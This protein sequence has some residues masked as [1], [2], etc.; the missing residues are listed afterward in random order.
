MHSTYRRVTF[1]L[2]I[3]YLV[4]FMV[5]NL[6]IWLYNIQMGA[7]L[8]YEF[9]FIQQAALYLIKIAQSQILALICTNMINK[10]VHLDGT[11]HKGCYKK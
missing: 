11:Y 2:I 4:V 1:D 10:S 8:A 9:I 7:M 3:M 5:R 6:K